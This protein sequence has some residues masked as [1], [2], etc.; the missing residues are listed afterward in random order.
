MKVSEC[1]ARLKLLLSKHGDVECESD[2]PF[3][4]RS[5]RVGIV[6]V[7]PETARLNSRIIDGPVGTRELK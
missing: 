4:H 5:F 6:V 3:C 2:C 7:A 1:I